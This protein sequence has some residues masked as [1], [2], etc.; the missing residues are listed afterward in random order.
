M[1]IA[2]FRFQI[3]ARDMRNLEI[4]ELIKLIRDS[5]LGNYFHLE[6]HACIDKWNFS[7][8]THWSLLN[9]FAFEVKSVFLG[10]MINFIIL[11]VISSLMT[12]LGHFSSELRKFSSIDKCKWN[13]TRLSLFVC[14]LFIYY[15][16]HFGELFY[17][18]FV[19]MIR[20]K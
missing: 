10:K 3:V 9:K 12:F 5:R 1:K 4:R 20:T 13:L 14:W 15:Y 2:S 6:T 8:W 11:H 18:F 19:T 16:T 17:T 7:K